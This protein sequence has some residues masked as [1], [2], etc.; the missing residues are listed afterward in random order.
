MSLNNSFDEVME[1]GVTNLVN[2][3]DVNSVSGHA[4]FAVTPELFNNDVTQESLG[5]HINFLNNLT[6]QAEQATATI[7]RTAFEENN[8]LVSMDS[9]LDLGYLQIQSQHFLKQDV[10]DNTL[11]GQAI[12]TI[13]YNYSEDLNNYRDQMAGANSELAAKLFG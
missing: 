13:D 10:G 9:T 12:T 2:S 11:Y 5:V 4:T 6:A 8:D 3:A 1:S 7:S